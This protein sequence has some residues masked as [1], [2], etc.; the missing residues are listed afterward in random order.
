MAGKIGK[1][2]NAEPRNSHSFANGWL[3]D[4]KQHQEIYLSNVQNPYATYDIPFV[5]S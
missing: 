2:G 5:G 3:M 4:G 1:R